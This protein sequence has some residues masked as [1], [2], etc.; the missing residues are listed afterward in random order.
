M[1]YFIYFR[2]RKAARKTL[3]IKYKTTSIDIIWNLNLSIWNPSLLEAEHPDYRELYINCDFEA[4]AQFE[5]PIGSFVN[6]FQHHIATFGKRK[7][8]FKQFQKFCL[9][10]FTSF[11]KF[12]S[13]FFQCKTYVFSLGVFVKKKIAR[14]DFLIGSCDCP[15]TKKKLAQFLYMGDVVVENWSEQI[16]KLSTK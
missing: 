4:T 6:A 12:S 9:Q 10:R 5:F 8:S 13:P 2:L 1:S 7:T 15:S 11:K 14:W 16:G 3:K